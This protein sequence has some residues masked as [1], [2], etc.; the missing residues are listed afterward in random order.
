[1]DEK[2]TFNSLQ[3][4]NEI[5]ANLGMKTNFSEKKSVMYIKSQIQ[6]KLEGILSQER[7][8]VMDDVEISH[9]M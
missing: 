3:M 9:C 8:K 2:Q 1:M 7:D 4:E 5:H 6:V